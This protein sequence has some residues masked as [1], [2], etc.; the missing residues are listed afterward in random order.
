MDKYFILWDFWKG[1]RKTKRKKALRLL[2]QNSCSAAGPAR[3]AAQCTGV[4]ARARFKPDGRGPGVSERERGDGE[5]RLTGGARLS[6]LTLRQ[7]VGELTSVDAGHGEVGRGYG[8]TQR[9]VAVWVEVVDVT[10]VSWLAGDEVSRRRSFGRRR[11][12][13]FPAAKEAGKKGEM[14]RG[15][16]GFQIEA[17]E[18]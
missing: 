5:E 18:E 1:D 9:R 12:R 14:V 2:G 13:P 10:G 3:E 15:A 6:S 4:R 8:W 16:R 7:R 11:L 17:E